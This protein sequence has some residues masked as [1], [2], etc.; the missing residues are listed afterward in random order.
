MVARVNAV[1]F[2]DGLLTWSERA[3]YALTDDSGTAVFWS[4]PGGELRYDIHQ[5]DTGGTF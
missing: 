5:G 3:G 4:N 1:G 2:S